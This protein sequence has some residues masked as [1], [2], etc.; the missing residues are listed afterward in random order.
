[1][2]VAKIQHYGIGPASLGER[3]GENRGAIE[4]KAGIM[5]GFF[6]RQGCPLF[7]NNTRYK[8]ITGLLPFSHVGTC[9]L[10][11]VALASS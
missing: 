9:C 11:G 6:F 5:H 3:E 8:K 4:K 1:L 10:R 7:L 2:N